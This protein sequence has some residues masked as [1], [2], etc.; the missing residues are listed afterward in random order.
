DPQVLQL[1]QE[2]GPPRGRGRPRRLR[3]PVVATVSVAH[4]LACAVKFRNTSCSRPPSGSKLRI[5]ILAR[6][7]VSRIALLIWWSSERTSESS[8]RSQPVDPLAAATFL[9]V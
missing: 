8:T 2:L 5:G 1:R 7:R 3:A 6:I 9:T 4:L